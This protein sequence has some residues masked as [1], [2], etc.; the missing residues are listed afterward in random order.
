MKLLLLFPFY[1]I[2]VAIQAFFFSYAFAHLAP[3][4]VGHAVLVP[5][6]KCVVLAIFPVIGQCAFPAFLLALLIGV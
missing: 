5:F 3:V 2:V 6:W 4:I 1:M